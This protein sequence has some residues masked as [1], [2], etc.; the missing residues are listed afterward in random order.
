MNSA[1]SNYI[2]IDEQQ[3]DLVLNGIEVQTRERDI[4][5]NKTYRF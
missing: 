2:V 5:E 4:V 1:Y 3:L